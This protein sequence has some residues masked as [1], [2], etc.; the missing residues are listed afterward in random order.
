MDRRFGNGE[1]YV[2]VGTAMG[3]CMKSLIDGSWT[4]PFINTSM[5]DSDAGSCGVLADGSACAW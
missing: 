2:Y 4:Q 5:P 3:E 1:T